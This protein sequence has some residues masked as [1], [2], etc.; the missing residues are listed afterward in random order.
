LLRTVFLKSLRDQRK[1]L[2]WWG[3]GA[4]ALTLVTILFY[5]VFSQATDLSLLLEDSP[6]AVTRL[7][8]GGFTDFTSPEGWLNSQLFVLMLPS[9]FFVYAIAQGSAAIAGEEER[10]TL[11][12]LLSV[13]M[14]RS[15]VLAHKSAA[16]V[17][18]LLGLAFLSWLGIVI[19]AIIVDMDIGLGR[20]A[21]AI[22]SS[23]LLGVVFGAFATAMG[24]ATG[25]RGLS[26]GM[27]SGV[28][29]VSYLAN[30]LGPLVDALDPVTKLSPFY[31]YISADPLSNGLNPVHVA[32][33]VGTA[34]ILFAISAVTFERRDLAV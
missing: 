5:P 14:T 1:P 2:M 15:R 6:E 27:A 3:V 22:L 4:V 7:F 21:Q 23:L 30:A 8:A 31:Y 16:M 24:C 13:P 9:M 34:G 20:A 12:L 26:I 18:S 28:V 25:K 19:G 17:V 32:V 10:G 29:V 33:L 11:D